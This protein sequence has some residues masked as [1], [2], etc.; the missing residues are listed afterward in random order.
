MTSDQLDERPGA[1]DHDADLPGWN[2]DPGAPIVPNTSELDTANFVG[3]ASETE[4]ALTVLADGQNLILRDPR[5]MGKTF[6]LARLAE[7]AATTGR[8]HVVMIDY[9]HVTSVEDFL[10]TTA[11][12][13]LRDPGLPGGFRQS[14]KAFFDNTE[15]ALGS[16]PLRLKKAVANLP[17]IQTLEHVFSRL[18]D[19]IR[20]EKTVSWVIAMDEV[21]DAILSIA[22]GGQAADGRNLLH[23][24]RHLRMTMPHIRWILAGSTGFHHALAACADTTAP[25][26]DLSHFPFGP[27]GLADTVR[28]ARRL[29]LGIGRPITRQAVI[30][31]AKAT[32]GIP[33]L[34]Q[35]LFAHLRWDKANQPMTSQITAED[36]ATALDDLIEDRDQ[37]G[38]LTYFVDRLDQYYHADDLRLARQILDWAADTDEPHPLSDLPGEIRRHQRF[39]AVLDNLIDDHYLASAEHGARL[40]WRYRIL[41]IVYRRRT[42][43]D[44]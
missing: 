12:H 17:A 3:R 40:T 11:D 26:N 25:L 27:L 1:N 18:D 44:G 42:Q 36:V 21:P 38:D 32:D 20:T 16:G 30:A 9:Q 28:L 8:L 6:W 24:L 14:L 35:A 29:A 43:R 4:R 7:E 15:V 10:L 22:G 39:R 2:D 13:L 19:A 31:T 23:S 5:R 41:R 34:V 33:W 37:S